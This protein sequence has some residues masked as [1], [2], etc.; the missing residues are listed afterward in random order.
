M[1]STKAP[2]LLQSRKTSFLLQKGS[3]FFLKGDLETPELLFSGSLYEAFQGEKGKQALDATTTDSILFPDNLT[4][5][6]QAV[7]IILSFHPLIL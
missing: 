6:K 2:W 7:K 1:F 3:K 4:Y 5:P